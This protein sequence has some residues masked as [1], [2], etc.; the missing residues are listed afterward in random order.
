MR[1]A[2]RLLLRRSA[3]I[4]LVDEAC[5]GQEALE[6]VRLFRPDVLVMDI[7]MPVLDGISAVKLAREVSPA[8][9]V[10]L[11][12]LHADGFMMKKAREAGAHGLLPKDNIA[13]TLVSAIEAV[14]RGE[15]YFIDLL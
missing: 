13:Q 4:E 5:D 12:S 2:L 3:E 1:T 10:I 9:R 7:R 8:T 14:H 15:T 11:M 6:S